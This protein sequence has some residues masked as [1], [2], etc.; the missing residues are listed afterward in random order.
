MTTHFK[1]SIGGSYSDVC[2]RTDKVYHVNA[3]ILK[4]FIKDDMFVRLYCDSYTHKPCKFE[5]KYSDTHYTADMV[6]QFI[7]L[8]CRN[9]IEFDIKSIITLSNS[10]FNYNRDD[11]GKIFI[12][13]HDIGYIDNT[14]YNAMIYDG[15][16]TENII[17]H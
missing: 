9:D 14:N 16:I 17:D 4:F 15:Y 11:Y 13:L 1:L 12:Y 5:L 2:V 8:M 7:K 3:Q 6:I 10:I